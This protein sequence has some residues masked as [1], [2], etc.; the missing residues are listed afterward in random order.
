[1]DMYLIVWPDFFIFFYSVLKL[2]IVLNCAYQ[3]PPLKMKKKNIDSYVEFMKC[4]EVLAW[5]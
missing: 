2:F 3:Y 5:K 4:I 1:M